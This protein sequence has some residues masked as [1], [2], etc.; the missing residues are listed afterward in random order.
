MFTRIVEMTTKNGKARELSRTINDKVLSLLRNQPGFVDEI[1]LVSD[2][3]PDRLV[4]LSFWETKEEAEIYN[5]E[6]FPKVNEI[7]RG[8]ID[9]PPKVQTFNVEDSTVHHISAGKAA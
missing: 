7:I 4:A 8:Q 3:N 5:R 9:G 1:M 6:T 2:Q